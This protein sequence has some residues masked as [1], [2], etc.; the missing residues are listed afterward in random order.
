[1]P[2]ILVQ[3]VMSATANTHGSSTRPGNTLAVCYR[4]ADDDDY[5][6]RKVSRCINEVAAIAVRPTA[7]NASDISIS[8]SFSLFLSLFICLSLS[9]SRFLNRV[10][11]IR[12]FIIR[13]V[14][15]TIMNATLLLI[16]TQAD[17]V[18]QNHIS[19]PLDIAFAVELRGFAIPNFRSAS[20]PVL[21]TPKFNPGF[22]NSELVSFFSFLLFFSEEY[23][24]G[25]LLRGK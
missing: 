14:M 23:S 15:N 7:V 3:I 1:M 10:Y 13:N 4:V 24:F 9:F 11:V 22:L 17:N 6:R 18:K 12:N 16:Y 25:M 19:A 20:L 2:S 8:L 21:M 5:R